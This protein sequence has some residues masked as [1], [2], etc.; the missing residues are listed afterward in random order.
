[1]IWGFI[2]NKFQFD[3]NEMKSTWKDASEVNYGGALFGMVFLAL[4]NHIEGEYFL[5]SYAA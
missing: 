5:L 3:E 4:E 1:M 2:V